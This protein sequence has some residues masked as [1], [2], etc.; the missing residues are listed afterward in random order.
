MAAGRR[1]KCRRCVSGVARTGRSDAAHHRAV[2]LN[3]DLL[4]AGAVVASLG[5]V[6]ADGVRAGRLVKIERLADR[7]GLLDERNLVGLRGVRVAAGE[8]A[9]VARQAGRSR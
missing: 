8:G 6:D 1:V 7:A 5:G 2:Y 4:V 9:A 3:L